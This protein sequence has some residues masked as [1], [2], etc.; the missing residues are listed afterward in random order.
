[1]PSVK[2]KKF[3]SNCRL[4]RCIARRE[5]AKIKANNSR[6]KYFFLANS[7]SSLSAKNRR[8]KDRRA[9]PDQKAKAR[10][11]MFLILIRKTRLF[12]V[13]LR[14]ALE[15]NQGQLSP[16]HTYSSLAFSSL[17]ALSALPHNLMSSFQQLAPFV[18]TSYES[19]ES[20]K[21]PSL[22]YPAN[23]SFSD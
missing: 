21:Y 8:R 7:S 1:M 9:S 5:G 4:G 2:C 12:S 20:A 15:A 17:T 3:N 19:N 14:S 13:S 16:A 6:R 23:G 10:Y 11:W 18:N 22:T